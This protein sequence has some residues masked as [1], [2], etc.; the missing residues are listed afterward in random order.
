MLQTL[1]LIAAIP[2]VAVLLI[3]N[4]RRIVFTLA[5]LRTENR[6]HEVTV[7]QGYLP[8][9]LVLVS[10]RDEAAMIP[11]LCQAL[12][13]LDYP[14]ESFQDVLIDDASTDGTGAVM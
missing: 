13:Q 14:A 3:F 2:V 11:G 5:I 6:S 1:L 10:C 12:S 7:G 4:L 8:G 9:V